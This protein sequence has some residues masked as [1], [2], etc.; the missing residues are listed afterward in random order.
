[1]AEVEARRE[2]RRAR[3]RSK[4]NGLGPISIKQAVANSHRTDNG[5]VRSVKPGAFVIP[6]EM[7]A[8]HRRIADTFAN[9]FRMKAMGMKDEAQWYFARARQM[10][11]ERRKKGYWLK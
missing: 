2:A 3:K 9:G 8:D 7:K 11:E 4:R 1:M 6:E 5:H 10:Q